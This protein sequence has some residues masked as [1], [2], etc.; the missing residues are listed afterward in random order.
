MEVCSPVGAKIFKTSNTCFP[1]KGLVRLAEIW[2]SLHPESPIK[3]SKNN[4]NKNKLWRELDDK[5]KST[6]TCNVNA[7]EKEGC[8]VDKLKAKSVDIIS[9]SILPA[10]PLPWYKNP[11]E[12]LSNIDIENVMKQYHDDPQ[13]KYNFLG[14]FSI[15]FASKD[16]FGK[17]LYSEI[18][19]LNIFNLHQSKNKIKYVGLITNLDKHN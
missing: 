2:N 6:N 14:V 5:M 12:W 17:C 16:E 7:K 8:W 1:Y 19:S 4:T 9:Q 13:Y 15:D 10:K 18:C 11:S 3:I